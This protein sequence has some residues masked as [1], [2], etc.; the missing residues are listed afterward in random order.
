MPVPKWVTVRSRARAGIACAANMAAVV[1]RI[2][3][4]MFIG[5]S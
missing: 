1:S 2:V 4:L 3:V 5:F